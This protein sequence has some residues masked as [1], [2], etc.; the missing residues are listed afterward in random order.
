MVTQIRDPGLCYASVRVVPH[1]VAVGQQRALT[2]KVQSNAKG[3]GIGVLP[4]GHPNLSSEDLWL[5]G[6]SGCA[7]CIDCSWYTNSDG[8]GC[9][10]HGG[11]I[12][13][14]PVG[15]GSGVEVR[16]VVD[17]R[18]GSGNGVVRFYR[19]GEALAEA[20]LLPIVFP[21]E[22]VFVVSFGYACGG[23]KILSFE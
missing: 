20:E 21:E 22:A 6:H 18:R 19:N 23:V 2:V 16:A 9:F 3:V 13:D 15:F 8:I 4:V 14:A 10:W 17:R 12:R 11:N 7:L 1:C 5:P